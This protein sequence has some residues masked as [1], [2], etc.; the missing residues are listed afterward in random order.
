MG[1]VTVVQQAA[2]TRATMRRKASQL[3]GRICDDALAELDLA[4][5]CFFT[6][7]GFGPNAKSGLTG[8]SLR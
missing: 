6:S 7:V 4:G 2:C 3:R 5:W 8:W 1:R